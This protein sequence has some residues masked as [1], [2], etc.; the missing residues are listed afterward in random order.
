MWKVKGKYH[1]QPIEDIDEFDTKAEAEKMLAEY[2]M[3]LG[4]EWFLKTVRCS[5]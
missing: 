5:K 1:G 2:R 4:S 3:E